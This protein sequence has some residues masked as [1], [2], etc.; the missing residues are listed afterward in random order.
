[1]DVEGVILIYKQHHQQENPETAMWHPFSGFG[2]SVTSLIILGAT[3]GF[4][5]ATKK[6]A[7]YNLGPGG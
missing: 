2:G 7:T 4:C 1:M 3:W 5:R 6:H